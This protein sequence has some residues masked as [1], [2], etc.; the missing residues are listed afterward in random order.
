MDYSNIHDKKLVVKGF[1]FACSS[2]G[3]GGARE[4]WRGCACLAGALSFAMGVHVW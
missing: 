4:N 2:A 3:R 1:G